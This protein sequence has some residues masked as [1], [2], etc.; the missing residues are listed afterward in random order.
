MRLSSL[1]SP[2]AAEIASVVRLW[3]IWTHLA[4]TTQGVSFDPVST[5]LD[6]SQLGRVA[7]AGDFDA[8]SLYTY[9][10]QSEN[11][12]SANGSQSLIIQMP[13]GAFASLGSADADIM[14]MCEFV[15]KN[16]QS[17]GVV[18]GGNFT[19]FD[20]LEAQ[21]VALYNP[22]TSQIT[23]LPGLSGKVTALLCDQETNT[24]YVG[25]EF[26]GANSTNAVIWIGTTGWANLPFAGFNG[27][28]SSIVKAPNGN[29]IFGGS[30]NGLGNTTTPINKDQ[31]VVNLQSAIISA[32]SSTITD[33]FSDPTSI[34]CK[35]SGQDGAGNTWLLADNTPGYW[36]AQMNFG[37][38]PTKVRIWNTHQ[39]GRGTKTFRFTAFPINGIMNFTY[40]DPATGQNATCDARCPLSSNISAPYTDFRFVNVIGMNGF[41]IDISDWYGSGG[42]LDGVELFQDGKFPAFFLEIHRGR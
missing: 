13:N 16:G 3:L 31:Q 35:T 39:D 26:K 37:Y 22:T 21:G 41:R 28:V 18:V 15:M 12:F 14:A 9:Q 42:G 32:G 6:L 30:F 8:I 5:N 33:G 36:E 10:Q 7:L 20:G 23:P 29:V 4:V 17:A 1:F 2:T 27:P 38:E 34:I 19:S 25:G 11:S 40:A 24:V